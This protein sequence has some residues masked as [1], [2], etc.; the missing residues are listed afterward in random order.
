[1]DSKVFVNKM[2]KHQKGVFS[3][4]PFGINRRAGSSSLHFNLF[5]LFPLFYRRSQ[6][7][8]MKRKIQN[9]FLLSYN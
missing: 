1:M 3:S 8:V 7:L 2:E 6:I 5:A 4:M 9:T